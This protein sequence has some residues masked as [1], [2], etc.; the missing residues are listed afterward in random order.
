MVASFLMGACAFS[1]IVFPE[2]T[3]GIPVEIYGS[4]IFLFEL[5]MGFW[6]LLKGLPPPGATH[7]GVSGPVQAGAV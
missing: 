6:L 3:R 7:D 4:P 5:T 1:F 2:L